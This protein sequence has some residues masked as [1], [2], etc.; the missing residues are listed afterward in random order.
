MQI[1]CGSPIAIIASKIDSGEADLIPFDFAIIRAGTNATDNRAPFNSIISDYGD[2]VGICRKNNHSIQIV[3][4]AIFP[5][6][7]DHNIIDPTI[8]SINKHE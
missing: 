8:R 4:S 1:F 2:L 6:S 3:L 7:V 5:S